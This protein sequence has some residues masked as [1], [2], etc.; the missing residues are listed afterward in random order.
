M[1]LLPGEIGLAD[2]PPLD[3]ERTLELGSHLLELLNGIEDYRAN[4][5]HINTQ[6]ER[7]AANEL[8]VSDIYAKLLRELLDDYAERLTDVPVSFVSF[9]HWLITGTNGRHIPWHTDTPGDARFLLNVGDQEA[10]IEVATEWDRSDFVPG[11]PG[12]NDEL[13]TASVLLAIAPGQMYG[14]NTLATDFELLRPH[15]TPV[16]LSR[17][18]LRTSVYAAEGWQDLDT[19]GGI[20][21]DIR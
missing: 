11:L 5:I 17:L 13:P 3:P 9:T 12:F 15:Q 4:R 2:R 10:A 8:V 20:T 1:V 18:M 16:D 19:A 14:S 21:I 6:G 7:T